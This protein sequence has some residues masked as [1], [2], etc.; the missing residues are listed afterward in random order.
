MSIESLT[1]IKLNFNDF[2]KFNYKGGD[3]N[4]VNGMARML[5]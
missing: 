5:A 1:P 3:L 4:V 2:G